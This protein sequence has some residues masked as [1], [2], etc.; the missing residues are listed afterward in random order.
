MTITSP[1]TLL[2]NPLFPANK[3]NSTNYR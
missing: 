2:A 1:A 3:L